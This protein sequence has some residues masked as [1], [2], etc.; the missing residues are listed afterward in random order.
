MEK[1]KKA[2]KENLRESERV[3]WQGSTEPFRPLSG[4]EARRTLISWA[5]SILFLGVPLI[6]LLLRGDQRYGLQIA[7]AV[8][9]ALPFILPFRNHRLLLAQR[10]YITSERALLIRSSGEVFSME[11][12]VHT[13]LYHPEKQGATLALGESLLPEGDKQ[14]RWRSLHPKEDTR[15]GEE[16][17]VN[18]LV[19]YQPEKAEEAYRLLQEK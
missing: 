2:L 17:A 6:L 4:R 1:I 19:F 5:L 8:L 16:N 7:I 14:L 10:Y 18:G 3:L 15:S 12:P 11:L 9:M 13:A